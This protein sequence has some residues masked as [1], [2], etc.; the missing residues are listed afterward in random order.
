MHFMKAPMHIKFAPISSPIGTQSFYSSWMLRCCRWASI[1]KMHSVHPW[2]TPSV[3]NHQV[4]PSHWLTIA[5][6]RGAS[7]DRCSCCSFWCHG[8]P[9]LL[10]EISDWG[11]DGLI[12][13]SSTSPSL[14]LFSNCKIGGFWVTAKQVSGKTLTPPMASF[15]PAGLGS[16]S[17]WICNRD[18]PLLWGS[19]ANHIGTSLGT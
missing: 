8:D 11:L 2:V 10:S 3:T 9:W 17:S 5:N 7:R 15:P 16:Q 18:F 13:L 4:V 1:L 19:V 14:D 6:S 12:L